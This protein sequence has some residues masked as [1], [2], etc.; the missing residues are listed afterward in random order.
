[1]KKSL[2]AEIIIYPTPVYIVGTYDG[3][4]RPNIMSVAWGGVCCS[5]PPCLAISLRKATYTYDNL[6]RN[7][8]FTVNIPSAGQV[9]HADYAG[10]YSG[11]DENKFESLG[12]TPVKADHVHAPYVGEFP[13]VVECRVIHQLEIGLHTQFIGEILDVKAEETVLGADGAVDIVKLDP[14]TY[15]PPDRG[16]YR[17]GSLLARAFSVGRKENKAP[18]VF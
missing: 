7:K 4:D 11:R 15:Y 16:Y 13:L 1:M 18:D 12:L 6:T 8:A 9:H 10:I 14:F 3:Q 5:R 17:A 2:G